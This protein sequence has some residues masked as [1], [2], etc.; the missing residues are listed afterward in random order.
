MRLEWWTRSHAPK[1]VGEL[2]TSEGSVS[3]H[4]SF[5]TPNCKDM[6]TRARANTRGARW[7][8]IKNDGTDRLTDSVTSFKWGRE[9][10]KECAV[11]VWD[12]MLGMVS[13]FSTARCMNLIERTSAAAGA[14]QRKYRWGG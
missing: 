5:D 7:L 9:I 12:W 6:C 1:Y 11:P 10:E 4:V 2:T 8:T 13:G 3:A 14:Q